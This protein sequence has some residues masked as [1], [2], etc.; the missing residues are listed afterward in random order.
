MGSVWV[1]YNE[2]LDIRVAIKVMSAVSSPELVARFEREAKA[3]AQLQ[4]QH[5]VQVFEHGVHE[6]LPYIVMELLTG[7]DLKQCFRREGRLSEGRTARI[8]G[9]VCKALRRAHEVGII[10]RDLKPANI[11][12]AQRDD[13]EVVKVLDF[14]IAKTMMT[15]EEGLTQTGALVGTPHYMSPEQARRSTRHVD[16]RSDLWAVGVIAYRALTGKLPYPGTEIIDVLLRVCSDPVPTPSSIAPD[17]SPEVDFFFERALARDPDDRFQ[18]AREMAEALAALAGSRLIDSMPPAE[19]SGR[20]TPI[21]TS[22]GRAQQLGARASSRPPPPMPSSRRSP[23]AP[24]AMLSPRE[25]RTAFFGSSPGT[26]VAAA[27]PGGSQINGVT[28]S[29]QYRPGDQRTP[30]SGMEAAASAPMVVSSSVRRSGPL[31]PIPMQAPIVAPEPP[32]ARPVPE[33]VIHSIRPPPRSGARWIVWLAA[34]AA[35]LAIAIVLAVLATGS[36]QP[37]PPGP[38]PTGAHT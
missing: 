36:G 35:F 25:Q 23:A 10:H 9:D 28:P 4:S 5:V 1:A 7:E 12:L 31:V 27:P 19:L 32:A 26:T 21:L 29:L 38:A 33:P 11:F 30:P 20:A 16:H 34:G 6:G 22:P 14:G 18:S 8:L 24:G 3:A 2:Q 17:L 15:D 13:E 37:S